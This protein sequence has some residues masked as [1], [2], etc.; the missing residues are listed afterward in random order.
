MSK[1]MLV[2]IVL[3]GVAA[4]AVGTFAGYHYA[5]DP[6]PTF[7]E[8]VKVTPVTQAYTVPHQECRDE[9][10]TKTRAVEDQHQIAG[11]ALGAVVGGLIGNQVGDG[12]G[13][14]A[15][16]VLGAA[17]GGYA[18]KK[19][20]QDMQGKDTYTVT[21]RICKTSQQTKQKV[22]GYDVEYRLAGQL[23]TVRM[24]QK[25]GARIPVEQGKLVLTGQT[26]G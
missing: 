3:G 2:G 5:G 9:L 10:V 23:D 15:A 21:E 17:A 4:T 13:K 25:P 19:V 11:T 1:S 26:G 14:K 12:S 7:A 6:E 24:D 8:V 18:G 20:Q 16:T 22:V